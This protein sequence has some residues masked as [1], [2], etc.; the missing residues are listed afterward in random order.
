MTKIP[1]GAF[2]RRRSG[3]VKVPAHDI[4][5]LVDAF[6]SST[7]GVRLPPMRR[8]AGAGLGYAESIQLL[9]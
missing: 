3:L 4:I 6:G 8:R 5:M 2:H 1:S 9:L 7:G